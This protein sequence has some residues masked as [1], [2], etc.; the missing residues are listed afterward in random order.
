M[1]VGSNL[2]E[3][4]TELVYVSQLRYNQPN[5]REVTM[6]RSAMIRA[7]TDEQL[8]VEVENILQ[9]LGL[10]PSEAINLF[11]AQIRLRRGIP[12]QIEL[13]NEETSRIFKETEAGENLVECSDADDVFGKLGL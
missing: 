10:T 4:P 6:S 8:K 1:V 13:P 3:S 2:V 9:K 7:R 11:Y 5:P 12:F